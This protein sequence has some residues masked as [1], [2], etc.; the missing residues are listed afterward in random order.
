MSLRWVGSLLATHLLLG[1]FLFGCQELNFDGIESK[2]RTS[3][4]FIIEDAPLA[5]WPKELDKLRLGVT[6]F[7]S[8][9]EIKE[10]YAPL[11][12]HLASRLGV[13][14]ELVLVDSYSDLGERMRRQEIDIGTF[15]PLSYVH[16]RHADPGLRLLLRQ[17]AD[18][19]DTYI[20]YVYTLDDV[21][22]QSILDL[23]GR[24]ICYVDPHSASGYLYPRLLIKRLGHDPDQFFSRSIFAHTHMA[25]MERVLN[26][27]VD[28]SAT[29]S[30]TFSIARSNG[31]PMHRI[32][33][34][35]KTPPIPFDAYCVRS[36]LPE[37]AVRR[38]KQE[39]LGLSTRTPDGLRVLS[40]KMKLNAWITA[41]DSDY[42]SVRE[43][44][45]ALN[46]NPK[47]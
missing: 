13:K 18:G 6:P 14:A 4:K 36:G 12:D 2:R 42:D 40:H 37:Q 21:P 41:E 23:A 34:L 29:Y 39:L 19:S 27:D 7:T 30:G 8:E 5:P 24:S 43:A 20:G 25:C 35:A 46:R 38:I 1:F 3:S 32:K 28:A 45:A 9:D 47:L 31:L 26:G 11:L 10:A 17:V 16:A 22:V 44:L 15:P 33:I